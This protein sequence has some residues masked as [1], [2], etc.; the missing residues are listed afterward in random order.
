ML[1]SNRASFWEKEKHQ[2]RSFPALVTHP[3]L[4][5][6]EFGAV[7]GG[8]SLQVQARG[9]N[10]IPPMQA[11]WPEQRIK[12]G[13][14]W[15]EER[16]NLLLAWRIW[17]DC[18]TQEG[19]KHC[20]HATYGHLGDKNGMEPVLKLPDLGQESPPF[21]EV[22]LCNLFFC[23]CGG[24]VTKYSRTGVSVALPHRVKMGAAPICLTTD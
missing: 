21:V 12:R 8:I 9:H 16:D 24:S 11:H 15:R 18:V 2:V 7:S 20:E 3:L 17:R 13:S 5:C 10:H 4:L 23:L 14:Y 6:F 1:R 19:R 22:C